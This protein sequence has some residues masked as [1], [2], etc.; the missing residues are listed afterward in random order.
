M[1]L[2]KWSLNQREKTKKSTLLDPKI[3]EY[4]LV[5]GLQRLAE[6]AHTG[7]SLPATVY[8]NHFVRFGAMLKFSPEWQ[9]DLWA[10]SWIRDQTI[11]ATA[12]Q[13]KTYMRQFTRSGP[14]LLM[15]SWRRLTA[16]FKVTKTYLKDGRSARTRKTKIHAR[17]DSTGMSLPVSARQQWNAE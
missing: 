4:V 1:Q 15:S 7:T 12:Y 9:Q 16:V 10:K 3:G 2:K 13:M 5:S 6:K 17:T 8:W 14:R 11:A